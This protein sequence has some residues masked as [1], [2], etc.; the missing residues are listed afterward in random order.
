MPR[1]RLRNLLQKLALAV[2]GAQLEGV[3]FLDGRAVGRVGNDRGVL[4]Q[5]LGGLAGVAEQVVLERVAAC[6]GRTRS[7]SRSCTP[8][9]GIAR[10]SASVSSRPAL[11]SSRR[12]P[13]SDR[14]S[15][16]RGGCRFLRLFICRVGGRGGAN[17]S[18]NREVGGGSGA[19]TGATKYFGV[20]RPGLRGTTPAGKAIGAPAAGVGAGATGLAATAAGDGLRARPSARR[21][22]GR[23]GLRRARLLADAGLRGRSLPVRAAICRRRSWAAGAA[24][25][26]ALVAEQ[27]RVW[28]RLSWQGDGLSPGPASS[29]RP[30]SLGRRRLLLGGGLLRGRG[31][32]GARRRLGRCFLLA[33]CGAH[34]SSSQRRLDP[35]WQGGCARSAARFKRRGL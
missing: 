28:R 35:A 14:P 29:L 8:T 10:T 16:S 32:L 24:L 27:S 18:A 3:L 21:R 17:R 31:A 23:R 34:G 20:P 19:C 15:A 7:A 22:R 6:A 13:A 25:A 4:A 5:V 33:G 11:R 1:Q 9:S 12:W 2:A 26:G 30:R